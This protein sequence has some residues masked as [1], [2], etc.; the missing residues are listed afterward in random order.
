[1]RRALEVLAAVPKMTQPVVALLGRPDEPTDAVEQFCVHLGAAL[2]GHDFAMEIV[3]VP[4][5]ERGW[6]AAL[7]DLQQRAAA[8]PGRWVLLQYTALAW[9]PRGFPLKV[10]RVIKV[11]R[12]AGVRIGVVY[13]DAQPYSSSRAVDKLRCFVQQRTMRQAMRSSDQAI[14]TV[15]REKLSWI[16]SELKKVVFIPVGAN[17]SLVPTD[18]ESIRHDETPT[19]AVFGVTGGVAGQDEVSQITAAVRF[20]AGKLGKL[21]LLVFGRNADSAQTSL[22][23]SL[24][25]LPVVLHV[26]G[27][28]PETDVE[29]L[30]HSSDVLLF[31]RGPI[32]SRRGSAIAGIACGLPVIAFAGSETAAPITDAGVVLVPGGN[33]AALGEALVRVLSDREYHARLAQRSRAAYKN[34]F[35]WSAI[36]ARYASVLKAPL[37]TDKP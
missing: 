31:V 11:L 2:R 27:V 21:R 8:W 20:A 5:K 18:V 22:Q 30:L 1:M 36:A 26:S 25:G 23:E 12:D 3:R 35:S 33:K 14:L 9:S 19:V 13:H 10:P 37:E 4:W 6:S 16:S 32:S 7:R 24:R 17:L 28:L 34:H 29:K 15:P